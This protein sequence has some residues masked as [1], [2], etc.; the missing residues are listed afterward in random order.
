M[1]HEGWRYHQ[2]LHLVLNLSLFFGSNSLQELLAKIC[3]T[4]G[5]EQVHQVV[6][7]EVDEAIEFL[8]GSE[9]LVR[10][11]AALSL[12]TEPCGVQILARKVRLVMRESASRPLVAASC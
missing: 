4:L 8:F 3:L 1:A 6:F 5:P 11:L 9:D 7:V 12:L 10:E 2:V